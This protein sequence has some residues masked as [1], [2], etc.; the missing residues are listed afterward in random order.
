MSCISR[1]RQTQG[2]LLPDPAETD[3]LSLEKRV[4]GIVVNP[5]EL[6]G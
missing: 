3:C 6:G 1:K 2:D 5:T 4:K